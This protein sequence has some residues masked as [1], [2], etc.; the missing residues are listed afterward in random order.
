MFDFW[1]WG[2]QNAWVYIGR[3]LA[4]DMIIKVLTGAPTGVIASRQVD[5][6][7]NP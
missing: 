3:L 4:H 5:T 1:T 2:D 7:R 6:R